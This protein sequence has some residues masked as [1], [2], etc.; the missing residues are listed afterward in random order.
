MMF[1]DAG[2]RFA[3]FLLGAGS[4]IYLVNILLRKIFGVERK[5]FFSDNRVN[6]THK[7][8]DRIVNGL[9]AVIVFVTSFAVYEYGPAASLYLLLITAAVGLVQVLVRAGFEKKYADNTNEYLYTLFESLTGTVIIVTFG[10]SL[11][12]EMLGYMFNI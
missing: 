9:S 4:S 2:W 8:W 10:V 11:F 6:E 5:E 7:K 3:L 12:P 1:E